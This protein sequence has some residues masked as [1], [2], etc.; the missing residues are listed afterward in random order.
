M[1]TLSQKELISQTR[2]KGW[3]ITRGEK[4]KPLPISPEVKQERFIRLIINAIDQM[5]LS[6]DLI[7]AANIIADQVKLKVE[8]EETDK[9]RKWNM[10]VIRDNRG[11]IKSIVAEKI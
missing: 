3:D 2:E 1:K 7:S 4:P 5:N 11:L 8:S 10:D 6:R 9:K